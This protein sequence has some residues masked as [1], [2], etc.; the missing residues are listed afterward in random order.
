MN[1]KRINVWSSPRNISTAFMYSW[2]Q[3]PDTT[4]VDEPLFAHFL[5]SDETAYRPSRAET[6]ATMEHDGAKVVQA[7]LF[8]KYETPIVFFKQ[9]TSHLINI[10][11]NFLLEMDNVILIRHPRRIIASFSKG[12]SHPSI[13]DVAIKMQYELYQELKAKNKLAAVLDAKDI[14]LHPEYMI[15][16]LC[17]QL[18]ISFYEEML[19]WNAGAR[20]EDGVWAKYWYHTVHQ[21]TGFAPYREKQIKLPNHLET[22]AEECMPYYEALHEVRLR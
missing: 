8:G 18:G 19:S 15:R 9:M 1:T 13:G 16:L 11:R 14:L 2:A 10:N 3:R 7:I 20:P 17:K 21:S 12:V 6:L 22:L 4:V 5:A